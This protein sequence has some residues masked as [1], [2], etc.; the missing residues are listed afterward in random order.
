MKR[1]LLSLLLAP[2]GASADVNISVD[3]TAVVPSSYGVYAGTDY[4]I[5]LD[6]D[7]FFVSAEDLKICP[8]YCG[9]TY[10]LYGAGVSHTYHFQGMEF[11]ANAGLYLVKSNSRSSEY[12]E[13]LYYYMMNRFGGGTSANTPNPSGFRNDTK[14]GYGAEFGMRIPFADNYGMTL[15]YRHLQ[16]FTNYVMYIQ[17]G[18]YWHDPQTVK[19]DGFG[20]GV[21]YKF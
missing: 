6:T 20:F 12:N 21:Y 3:N 14:N 11:Y 19:Y 4:R 2:L 13:N 5:K 16:F 1:L 15:Y 17:G 10:R 9:I 7:R 8:W 18:G